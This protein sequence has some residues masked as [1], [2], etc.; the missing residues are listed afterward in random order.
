MFT[1]RNQDSEIEKLGVI[2]EKYVNRHKTPSSFSC[3]TR[4]HNR[5]FGFEN[6]KL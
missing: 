4:L 1:F 5:Y 3:K 2:L 6:L